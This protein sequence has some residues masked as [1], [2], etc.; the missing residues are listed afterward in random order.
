MYTSA[1]RR[2]KKALRK[3]IRRSI[4]YSFSKSATKTCTTQPCSNILKFFCIAFL[5]TESFFIAVSYKYRHFQRE[6]QDA[7]KLQ[8][9]LGTSSRSKFA[10]LRHDRP[11][12]KSIDRDKKS[13]CRLYFEPAYQ[14]IS[15]YHSKYFNKNSNLSSKKVL[16]FLFSSISNVHA[17]QTLSNMLLRFSPLHFLKRSRIYLVLSLCYYSDRSCAATEGLLHLLFIHGVILSS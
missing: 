5:D 14:T 13:V 11:F 6:N 16:T 15:K 4:A 10:V 17:R 9:D 7:S 1:T 8:N 3:R 12:S 2:E